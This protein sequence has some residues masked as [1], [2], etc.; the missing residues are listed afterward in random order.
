MLHQRTL[1]LRAFVALSLICWIPIA[2]MG[3]RRIE[4]E[5]YIKQYRG[6]AIREMK[7]YGIPAS[8]TLA[9]GLLESNA[10]ESSLSRRSNNHFGIKCHGWRG[11]SVRYTDDAPNEC[12][13]AYDRPEDSYR[14]HSIFLSTHDRYASLFRLRPDDYKGW[15]YGLKRAG[16]ATSPTYAQTLVFIIELYKLHEYDNKK[17]DKAIEHQEHSRKFLTTPHD[18]HLMND[19]VYI[20][21]NAGDS[22]KS[23]SKEFGISV[24]KLQKYNDRDKHS[25]LHVGDIIYLHKKRSKAPKGCYVHVIRENQSLY[26]ISQMYGIRLDKLM[27]L[28]KTLLKDD[29]LS[30]GAILRLR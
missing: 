3:Q 17:L 15:A 1:K 22:W 16:Y 10:G 11:R 23:M 28:N 13:R 24:R 5:N 26:D 12:F 2:L 6:V 30:V 18:P 20:V 14:D 4:Y 25:S 29:A 19:L 21:V 9:Q 8:I 27:K 7:K